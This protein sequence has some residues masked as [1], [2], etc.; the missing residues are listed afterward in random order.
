MS[1]RPTCDEEKATHPL[2]KTLLPKRGLVRQGNNQ[3][4]EVNVC[5][6]RGARQFQSPSMFYFFNRPFIS[7]IENNGSGLSRVLRPRWS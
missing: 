3:K 1:A 7:P 5:L 2:L 4:A 6:P